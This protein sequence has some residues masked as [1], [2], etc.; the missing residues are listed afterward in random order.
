M[1]PKKRSLLQLLARFQM[2]FQDFSFSPGS[3]SIVLLFSLAQSLGALI[4][5]NSPA[6]GLAVFHKFFAPTNFLLLFEFNYQNDPLVFTLVIQLLLLVGF[7]VFFGSLL[8]SKSPS[9]LDRRFR[10]EDYLPGNSFTQCFGALFV[11]LLL[12][13][14]VAVTASLFTCPSLAPENIHQPILRTISAMCSSPRH[15]VLI[16]SQ[17]L[18]FFNLMFAVILVTCNILFLTPRNEVPENSIFSH[19]RTFDCIYAVQKASFGLLFLARIF[20]STTFRL[21][22]L[23]PLFVVQGVQIRLVLT[24]VTFPTI[25]CI[26]TILFCKFFKATFLVYQLTWTIVTSADNHA[27]MLSPIH[28]LMLFAA[29]GF[30]VVK[31]IDKTILFRLSGIITSESLA[32]DDL[33][34]LHL[35]LLYCKDNFTRDRRNR[36]DRE[37][38]HSLFFQHFITCSRQ[39]C[40]CGLLKSSQD[41]WDSRSQSPLGLP[42]HPTTDDIIRLVRSSAF[43]RNFIDFQVDFHLRNGDY[44]V[45]LKL[46]YL[47]FTLFEQ[48][49]QNLASILFEHL[50]DV[51]RSFLERFDLDQLRQVFRSEFIRRN[52]RLRQSREHFDVEKFVRAVDQMQDL[53]TAF[54]DLIDD[55][56]R[57]YGH[58]ARQPTHP[59]STHREVTKLLLAVDK[60]LVVLREDLKGS[61]DTQQAIL[62]A[63]LF[64]QSLCPDDIQDFRLLAT[65]KQN[66]Q[67][68]LDKIKYSQ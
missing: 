28:L 44:R 45:S 54:L 46:F 4:Y 61:L 55:I 30:L 32:S 68:I 34:T 59:R 66:P 51:N 26:K 10:P 33:A 52:D 15:T 49:N 1:P 16:L 20:P 27:Q 56:V 64:F 50:D 29:M 9:G 13:P 58:L 31:L 21:L 7:S 17:V 14:V 19:S 12:Q 65:L 43:L 25:E 39:G 2:G 48:Q 41:L 63:L 40:V 22:T 47:E 62:L 42:A 60:K 36:A 6:S 3:A 57:L 23:I 67:K 53:E 18:G 5:L 35:L 8:A 38:L 37:E 11:P 24:K